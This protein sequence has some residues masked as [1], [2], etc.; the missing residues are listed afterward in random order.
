[1]NAFD[2]IILGG[3]PA[4][5]I[6]AERAARGGLK[7]AVFEKRALGGVCLNEGCIP[8]KALL[9]SAKIYEYAAHGEKY[10]VTATGVAIDQAAVIARKNVVVKQLVA[11][12]GMAMRKQNVTVID[13]PGVILGKGTQGF[14]ISA[15]GVEYTAQKL[16]IATGSVPILPPIPGLHEGLENGFVLTNR[17][18]LNLDVLPESLVVIGGGVIGLEMASYFNSVGTKVTVIEML[19]K[20]AGPTDSEI[21]DILL[22]NY[23]KKGVDFRLSC[24]VTAVGSDSVTYKEKDELKTIAAAKVLVSIGRKPFIEN[25]GLESIGVYTERGAIVTDDHLQT[26]RKSVV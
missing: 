14:T 15:D 21:S 12:V 18:I 8:S 7:V 20:I 5:Y 3:G 17:E 25:I 9:N 23:K 1:M 19:D 10:G 4:G 24:K 13:K 22:K 2:L 11:G 16:L 26:D 6:A